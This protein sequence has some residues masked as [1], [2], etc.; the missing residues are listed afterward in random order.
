MIEILKIL[1]YYAVSIAVLGTIGNMIIAY[2]SIKSKKTNSTFV[3]FRYLA[4]NDTLTLYFWNMN[5][6]IYSSFNLDIQNFNIYSCKIGNWIQFS[7]LQSSAWILV[8][9][10]FIELFSNQ[11]S[12]NYKFQIKLF[13]GIDFNR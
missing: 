6:F 11:N 8:N 9:F 13:Q 3:L 5:H 4:L 12:S 1:G 2:V 10:L 7:S